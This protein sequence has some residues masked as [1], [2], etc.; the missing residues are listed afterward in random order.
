MTDTEL[1]KF[2]L[3]SNGWEWIPIFHGVHTGYWMPPS[4]QVL[5]ERTTDGTLNIPPILTSRDACWEVF[6][7]DAPDGYWMILYLKAIKKVDVNKYVADIA[8]ETAKMTC[9]ERLEAWAEWV[10]GG[11]K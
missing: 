3:E 10:K 9:A 1:I 5:L 8:K 6:E 11:G 7:K 2:V 4:K